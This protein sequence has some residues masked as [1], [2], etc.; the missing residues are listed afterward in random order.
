MEWP[1]SKGPAPIAQWLIPDVIESDVCL[2]PMITMQSKMWIELY[3]HYRNKIL[4]DSGGLLD[5]LSAYLQ[6]MA[7]IDQAV[8]DGDGNS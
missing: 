8:A 3:V 6:A 7:I 1:G 2:K 4:A 5:Q